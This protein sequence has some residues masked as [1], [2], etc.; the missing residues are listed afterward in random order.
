MRLIGS[1]L[2]S[3]E[4][5]SAFCNRSWFPYFRRTFPLSDI[6]HR[7]NSAQFGHLFVV[8]QLKDSLLASQPASQTTS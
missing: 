8:L 4:K 7:S 1:S 3:G 6:F 5:Y 2:V